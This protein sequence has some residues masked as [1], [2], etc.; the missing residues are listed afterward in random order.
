[1]ASEGHLGTS[2][3]GHLRVDSEVI[4]RSYLRPFLDPFWTLSGKPQETSR[5]AFIWPWV[6]ALRLNMLNMGPRR[7]LG[8]Y[9]V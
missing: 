8:G 4:L 2:L 6:G 3:E 9:P 5:K 1:M 7:V